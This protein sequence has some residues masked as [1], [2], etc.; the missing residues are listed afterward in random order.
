MA[1]I[2][3][4]NLKKSNA[5]SRRT[6]ANLRTVNSA[7]CLYLP[8]YQ[9]LRGSTHESGADLIWRGVCKSARVFAHAQGEPDA[10]SW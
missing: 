3:G 5:E 1:N 2:I 7:H 10:P 8:D 4:T 9:G 6:I